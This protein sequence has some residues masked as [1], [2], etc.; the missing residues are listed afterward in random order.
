MSH[1]VFW[2]M[3]AAVAAPLL[4]EIPVGVQIPVVV[5]EVL[6][7]VVIG[8]HAFDLVRFEGFVQTM[9]GFAMAVTLF[10]AGMELDFERI[11]GRPL[12]LAV[13][14]WLVSL[15]VGLTVVGLLHVVPRVHAP[16]MVTIALCTTGL[17]VLIP[18]YRDGGQLDTPFGRLVLAAGTVGE[19]GPIIAM[20]LLLSQRYTTWQEAGYLL[21]F[22][23]FIVAVA[24]VGMGVRPPRLVEFLARHMHASTQL[25]VR[26]ALLTLLGLLAL[27][28]NLG[29]EGLFGAFAAGM[30]VGLVTRG[31]SGE[32]MRAKI[33]AVAFGWFYPFFFVGTGIKFNLA[34]VT[35]DATAALLLP[36]FLLLFLL[37][38]GAPVWLLYRSR[39]VAAQRLPFALSSAVPSLSIV[40][41]ITEIG[42]H[43]RV[44]SHDMAAAMIGASLLSVL[45]FP[46]LAGAM[47]SRQRAAHATQP[48]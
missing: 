12:G 47:L 13:G 20:S 32:P 48:R 22:L 4:A 30:V 36:V 25:P 19:V 14:G 16:L 10:M 29:F 8:P 39:I 21:A 24:A 18:I 23:L 15:G 33:D 45:V 27:A 28:E 46:T 34:A 42:L 35:A 44:M 7:G 26:I 2:L 43:E 40:V 5:L 38:R 17:G 31:R 37:I 3:L 6:L 41:V 9:F 11:R 1:T